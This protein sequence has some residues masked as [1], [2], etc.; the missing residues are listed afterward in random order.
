MS[1]PEDPRRHRIV[2]AFAGQLEEITI[3]N[4]F[5]T[6]AGLALYVGMIPELG[7]D[8]KGD[9]DLALALIIGEDVI[10]WSGLKA[11]ITVPI[12]THILAKGTR[13]E[14]WLR[15]EAALA[16][17]KKASELEDE[18]LGGLLTSRLKRGSTKTRPRESGSLMVGAQ[19]DYEARYAEAWGAPE[20]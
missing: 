10:T 16:D 12:E 3:E 6:D 1:D 19:I 18:F 2:A 20:A 5:R 15:V 8:E 7:G 14:S 13:L 11:F 9:P 4:G 17:V